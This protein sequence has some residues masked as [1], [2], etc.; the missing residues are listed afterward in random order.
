MTLIAP[1]AGHDYPTSAVAVSATVS[2]RILNG[3][4][5]AARRHAALLRSGSRTETSVGLGRQ[6][7]R[8]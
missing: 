1:R 6:Y 3:T 5:G 8:F 4:T 2:I 7:K